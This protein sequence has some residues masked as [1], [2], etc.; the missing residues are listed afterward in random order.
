MHTVPECNT[1]NHTVRNFLEASLIEGLVS[2]SAV[3][4]TKKI[5]H[6]R[7]YPEQNIS[8]IIE[9]EVVNLEVITIN[10]KTIVLRPLEI[11]EK[12]HYQNS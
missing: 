10:T 2:D 8:N 4:D 12:Y 5:Q 3:V 11:D 1:F 9:F 6:L 7:R